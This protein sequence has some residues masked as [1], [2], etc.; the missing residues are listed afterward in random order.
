MVAKLITPPKT[1]RSF[2]NGWAELDYI[3][4]KASYWL[5]ARSQKAKAVRYS[6]RLEKVLGKLPENDLAILREEGLALLH[7]LQGNIGEA[8]VHRKREIQLMNRL[9]REALS[10]KYSANTKAYM[11]QDRDDS[12]LNRRRA[13]LE[14]LQKTLA[15]QSGVN[16]RGRHPN[17]LP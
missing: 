7:E 9:H 13:I 12:A 15:E 3:C 6:R 4:N 2:A 5:Y 16:G 14:E 17:H 1:Q 8:I 10:V 11:L